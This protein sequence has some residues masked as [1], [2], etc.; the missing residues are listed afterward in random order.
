[1]VSMLFS[2]AVVPAAPSFVVYVFAA[3]VGLG[4]GGIVVMIYAIFPDIPDVDELKT[5]RRREGIYSSMIAFTRK[6]SA[7][8]ALFLVSNGLA[9]AGYVMPVEEV[10]GGVTRLIEQPQSDGFIL[11]LRL[12]FALVPLILVGFGLLVAFRYPLTSEIHR[13]LC[14]VLAVRRSGEQGGPELQTEAEDLSRI[15]IGE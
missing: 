9:L 10:V 15:L 6:V 11:L 1:M 12:I 8:V 13:R 14:R 4:I 2:F 5:G 3:L 7:A